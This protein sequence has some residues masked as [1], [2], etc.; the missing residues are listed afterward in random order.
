MIPD[1]RKKY[2]EVVNR[3]EQK[4][5][6]GSFTD[7][8]FW[9]HKLIGTESMYVIRI[10]PNMQVDGGIPWVLRRE[11]NINQNGKFVKFNCPQTLGRSCP[12]CSKGSELW[13]GAQNEMDKNIAKKHFARDCYY[14]NVLVNVDERENGENQGKVFLWASNMTLQKKFVSQIK[15]DKELFYSLLA[16]QGGHDFRIKMSKKNEDF[17]DYAE[18][19]FVA[20]KS[21]LAA[22]EAE[23]EAI[24]EKCYDLQ[25]SILDEKLFPTDQYMKEKLE[26]VGMSLEISESS[27]STPSPTPA[28]ESTP[29]PAVEKPAAEPEK[30]EEKKP[31]AEEKTEEAP[32]EEESFDDDLGDLDIDD[33]DI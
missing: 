22:S 16:E 24:L 5:G 28:V 7:D 13:S 32:Q 12:V 29:K 14:M 19:K 21:D 15:D 26:S 31:E 30:T 25:E 17:P 6:E 8:R 23:M 4:S 27:E 33:I 3:C 1:F 10:L 20:E 18:S 11:H 9:R 2:D